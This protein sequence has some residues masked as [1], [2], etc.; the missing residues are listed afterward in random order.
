MRVCRS[1]MRVGRRLDPLSPIRI[2]ERGV[3]IVKPTASG[4]RAPEPVGAEIVDP[5][6]EADAFAAGATDVA[7]SG[8]S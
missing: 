6:A 8:E 3:L 4:C 2:L 7:M 1:E 5:A